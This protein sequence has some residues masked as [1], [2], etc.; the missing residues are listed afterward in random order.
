MM[1]KIFILMIMLCA[2]AT[3]FACDICGCGVGSYYI[4][5]LPEFN[6][7]IFGLRYRYNTLTTHIGAGGQTSY[8][9]T[10]E[11]YR[12]LELWGGWTIGKRFRIM[13][14]LP[15]NFN[16]KF[17]QGITTHKNGL[18]DMNLQAYYQLLDNR[19]SAGQKLIVQSLWLGAG[20]KAPTGKY[21]SEEKSPSQ[22]SAN[23]FQLGTGS[24]DFTFNAMYD[25]RIQDAGIN[26]AASY[27]L[28]TENKEHYQYGNK[29]SLNAQAY[30]KFRVKNKVTIAP[31][32]GAL[33]ESAQ[34]DKDDGFTNDISGGNI[35]MGT[36]GV[37]VSFNKF[38]V[39]G[40]FQT[41][42][43]QD[44]AGG[45]VQAHNRAMVHVSILL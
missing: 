33:Y 44:L 38:S 26:F 41:P 42:L 31:N 45:F 30:Y 13:G 22:Q 7:K 14:T 5:I 29:V 2:S 37:E 28:N 9:T 23:I 17:N 39:G 35:A 8:L 25:L 40:N 34:K 10:D 32:I 3:T 21:D 36:A 27:K 1:K 24:V 4:G 20:I 19:A 11:T 12:T 43:H 15:V 16:E 18:G 6:K